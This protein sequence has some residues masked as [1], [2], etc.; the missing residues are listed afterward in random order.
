MHATQVIN[1]HLKKM[2]QA[3]HKKRMSALMSMVEAC[4]RGK[5]LS[6]TGLGRAIKNTVFEKH[7]IKRA[8]R[9]IGNF[10]LNQERELLYKTMTKWI[11]GKQKQPII[12]VDWSDLSSNGD[13]HLLR[14]SVPVGGRALA[15]YDEVHAQKKLN[16]GDIEKHFLQRLKR[17]LPTQCR[18]IIITD[19]GYRTPW[20]NAVEAQGWDFVGRVGGQTMITEQSKDEW[21]RVERIFDKARLKPRYVGFVDIVRRNPL[22]CHAYIMKKKKQG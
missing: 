15:I 19:A 1:T 17:L 13:Y 20:F 6:V 22:P 12:L 3:I 5:K 9:L 2:C 8:D 16:N 14:A 11:V 7:N 21:V 4:I 18:P 10:A